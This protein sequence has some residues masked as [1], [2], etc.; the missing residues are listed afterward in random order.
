MAFALVSGRS[1]IFDRIETGRNAKIG[2]TDDLS[3]GVPIH[4]GL[5]QVSPSTVRRA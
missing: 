2:A 3:E 1:G 4:T 5:F